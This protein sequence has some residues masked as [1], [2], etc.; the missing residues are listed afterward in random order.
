MR[1]LTVA[2]ARTQTIATS[3]KVIDSDVDIEQRHRSANPDK[4]IAD[5][6]RE[7][8]VLQCSRHCLIV[9]LTIRFARRSWSRVEEMG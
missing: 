6:R 9:A 5:N 1:I 8:S 2:Q 4:L 3:A 7:D